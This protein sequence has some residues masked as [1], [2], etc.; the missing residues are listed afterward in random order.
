MLLVL[1]YTAIAQK[2]LYVSL[3]GKDSNPGNLSLP[4]LSV[5]RAI[6]K[7]SAITGDV[8]IHIAE[9]IYYLD[10]TIQL[11]AQQF[12]P[13]SLKIQGSGS[14]IISGGK[15][16]TLNWKPFKN[17]IYVAKVAGNINFERLFCNNLLQVLARYPNYDSAA[18]TFNG[19]AADAIAPQRVQKW[20]NPTGGYLH[21]LHGGE[22]GGFHYRFTGVDKNGNLEMEG[23]WQNNRP[24]KLHPDM[25]FTENIF[26]ELDVPG[27]WFLDKDKKL[28]YFYPPENAPLSTAKIEVSHLAKSFVIEGTVQQP[29]RNIT[30]SNLH[31]THNERTFMETKEPLLR[32]DWT[33]YRGG[34]LLF[35]GTENC[36]VTDCT[37]EGLGGNAIVFSNYNK[38]N[39]V[40]GCHIYNIGANAVA[41]VGDM[42]AVRSPSFSYGSHIAYTNM[43]KT[44]D[45]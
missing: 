34:A 32:S 9:G 17:G 25:R 26:E 10:E 12:K 35:D 18:T 29:L 22:W 27:E 16:L 45:H 13:R 15:R 1:G 31:F 7:A 5:Q 8:V 38:N 21:A 11:R 24:S 44:P 39:L 2:S 43:D 28:L 23:G 19:T 3:K 36:T 42:K 30:F 40:T 37:F 4:F 33:F 14:V 41:F 6:T 20:L